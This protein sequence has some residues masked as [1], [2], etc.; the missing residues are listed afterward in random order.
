MTARR[1]ACLAFVAALLHGRPASATDLPHERPRLPNLCAD[2]HVMHNAA[3]MGLTTAAGVYN[4]CNSC[5]VVNGLS[6]WIPADQA[7]PG[8]SGSSHS[9]SGLLVNAARGATEPTNIELLSHTEGYTSSNPN[10][11]LKC[12]TCHDPHSQA[13]APLDPAAPA[14]GAGRHFMRAANA[15]NEMCVD[16]HA[17][18]DRD[19][20]GNGAWTGASLTHPVG[21]ASPAT[22]DFWNPPRDGSGVAQVEIQAGAATGGGVTTLDDT[23]K[24]WGSL[25]GRWVRITSGPNRGQTRQ[26]S[27]N[28]ATQLQWVTPLA[29]A[30]TAGTTYEIDADGNLSNDVVLSNAGTPST[31]TGNVVCMS[32]HG[33]HFADSDGATYDDQPRPG[34]GMLL[35]RDNDD[36]AC[37]ACHTV[38]LHNSA[39]TGS[40]RAAWGLGFTC[41]TCHTPHGTPNIYLVQA[42]V[43][44]PSSGA[45]AVDFRTMNTG[46]EAYG[47]VSSSAP[48]TG[49]CEVC[50]TDTRNGGEVVSPGTASFTAG[51]SGVTGAGTSWSGQLA[52][53]WEIKRQGD[54]PSAWTP[55]AAVGGNASLTLVTGGYRGTTG[56]GAWQ[57][58]NPRFR[59]TGTG[60]GAAGD[61]HY[62]GTCTTCH[63]HQGGFKGGE[64]SGNTPCGTCHD[65]DMEVDD[66]ARTAKYHHVMETDVQ[67]GGGLTT[68]PTAAAPTTAA[69]D[70]DK[71]CVQCHADHNVFRQDLNPSNT[72]GRGANLRSRIGAGPPVGNPPAASAPGDGAGTGNYAAVDASAAFAAGGVCLSCH[73]TAQAKN[74]VDQRSDGTTTTP[75]L[76]AGA[77]A[78]GAHAYGVA[79]EFTSAPGAFQVVCTKC[80]NDDLAKGYQSGGWR[81]SLHSSFERRLL[82]ALGIGAPTDPL[83]ERF[84]F[85]CHHE[86][87]DATPGGGPVKPAANLDWYGVAAMSAGAQ[88]VWD[89]F[90]KGAV[91]STTTTT[92]TLYFKPW[93]QEGP[94]APMPASQAADTGSFATNTLYLRNVEEPPAEPMPNAYLLSSGTYVPAEPPA[95]APR[96][97]LLSP[98]PGASAESVTVNTTNGSG[99]RYFRVAQLVSPPVASAF[100]WNG[101]QAITLVMRNVESNGNNN[102]NLRWVLY[103][104]NAAD[105]LGTTLDAITNGAE[106]PTAVANTSYSLLTDTA[107]TFAP[108]DKLLLEIELR[109]NSPT[110]TG[111]C[112]VSWGGAT[113][114][115]RL[116]LPATAAGNLP[117]FTYPA[118]AVGGGAWAGRSMS[119]GVATGLDELQS[120]TAAAVPAGTRLWSR[121]SFSSPAVAAATTTPA[122]PWT[123]YVYGRESNAAANAYVRYRIARWNA[124]DTAGPVIVPWTTWGAELG[125]TSAAQTITTPAGAAVALGVGDKIVVDLE[126]ETV[127]VTTG[128]TWSLELA[129]GA[130]AQSRVVAPSSVTYSY[131]TTSA[132]AQHRVAEHSGSHRPSTVDETLAW[133]GDNKHVECGDCHD[134]HAAG[135]ARHAIGTNAVSGVLAGASGAAAAFVTGTSWTAPTAYTLGAATKEHEICFKC[136]SGANPRLADWDAD[137]T[138]VGRD[139]SPGNQSYHPIASALPVTDPAATRGSDRLDAAQLWNGWTPGQTMYCSDCHGNDAASPAAQGPHGSAA[140]YLLAGPQTRWPAQ[141]GGTLWRLSNVTV[142][143]GTPNGLFCLNC[144]PMDYDD[145]D[146]TNSSWAG[147]EAHAQHETVNADCVNCHIVLP[148]GGGMSRLIGDTDGSM[149]ARYAFQGNKANLW[150]RSFIKATSPGAYGEGNCYS[151]QAGCTNHGA[152]AGENW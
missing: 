20:A 50:H 147:N 85:R 70:Q 5:H 117:E 6:S 127:A 38:K 16:C 101:A 54:P 2:C 126:L 31:T 58:A 103:R 1:L 108:G 79:G 115:S 142:G 136:H 112:T 12:T 62:D 151:T 124:D 23:A 11:R 125:I 44:T 30:L 67:L 84:C 71:S 99:V 143:Y 146:P 60:R 106:L 36:D 145:G 65:F 69:G 150:V 129:Y 22:L 138:D 34:D 114:S 77:F 73:A 39:V 152:I 51:A 89:A 149:P 87:D 140:S 81:F 3:G 123:I 66:G 75:P 139:F 118:P 10:K 72:A 95:P 109:A 97:R 63:T 19:D 141:A 27:G 93:A 46:I 111:T 91:L 98:L 107:V 40:S 32:C 122:A 105:T 130:A 92:S 9:W 90:Q 148:H 43:A 35:R 144:H 113:E 42:T 86:L 68:Y 83:E 28:S 56:S 134:P 131:A 17:A 80:H 100:T 133:L 59:N 74:T 88:D 57:A 14:A 94:A 137:W 121:V 21:V 53:G 49:P 4:L 120:A 52:A 82:G 78:A 8:T 96:S 15:A 135:G 45:R 47:L 29:V 61:E 48:G 41:R 55:I 26:L 18:R 110:N 128:G 104:W 37:T 64:S 25:G 102:C 33:V 116:V 132:G 119:P 13:D 76:A 7:I 24:S